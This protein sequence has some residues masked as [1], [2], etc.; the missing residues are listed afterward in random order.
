MP[1]NSQQEYA[2]HQKKTC[3]CKTENCGCKTDDCGCC[4]PGLV[5]VYDDNGK[6]IGCLTP[7]DAEVFKKET[8]E[9]PQG[10]VKLV[11]NSTGEILGCVSEDSFAALNQEVNGT[12]N[13]APISINVVPENAGDISAPDTL[14]LYAIFDPLNTTNQ[15]V[16][17]TSTNAGA[18]SVSP[19]GLV[20][21]IAPG[22]TTIRATSV[23]NPLVFGDR[24][25][26]VV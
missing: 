21:A 3:G 22:V 7:N 19:G 6:H 25:I 24:V 4:P 13:I 26:T 10:F 16:L 9:C 1:Y 23:E 11:N 5:A 8:L 12:P 2:K 14:Q 17:W 15:G 20:T 18:A